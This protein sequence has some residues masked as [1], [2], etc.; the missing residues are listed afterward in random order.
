MTGQN[1]KRTHKHNDFSFV[2][3]VF[4]EHYVRLGLMMDFDVSKRTFASMFAP[5]TSSIF[6]NSV[7]KTYHVFLC[8]SGTCITFIHCTLHQ[9]NCSP[10]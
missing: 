9:C 8:R 2:A 7:K 4:Y 5:T 3:R 6:C 10:C 1:C